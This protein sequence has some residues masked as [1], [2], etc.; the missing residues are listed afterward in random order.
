MK[1]NWFNIDAEQRAVWEALCP[2]NEYRVVSPDKL[3]GPLPR[4]LTEKFDSVFVAASGSPNGVVYWML[5]GNR[6]EW[7]SRREPCGAIDQQPF[8]IA[9]VGTSPL[10][11]GCLVQHGNWPGR[12][13]PPPC[14]LW[15]QVQ[16]SGIGQVYPLLEM[17][18]SPSGSI[19]DLSV[20]S[21]QAAF[22]VLVEQIK[23]E[24]L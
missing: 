15:T 9:F 11:S 19:Q 10:G 23:Y 8:G 14:G 2:V 3:P 12:T 13:T 17:P 18:N 6:V 20:G 5:N 24:F 21:Q 7:P 4:A 16:A 1:Y 22:N